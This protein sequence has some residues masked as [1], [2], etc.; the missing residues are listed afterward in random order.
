M[1][2]E[3]QIRRNNLLKELRKLEEKMDLP[4]TKLSLDEINDKL[5]LY[6]GGIDVKGIGKKCDK[7]AKLAKQMFWRK[8][9]E[10]QYSGTKLSEFTGDKSRFTAIAG[11]NYHILKCKNNWDVR[12]EYIKFKEFLKAN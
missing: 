9:V 7:E 2:K 5:K 11:R 3:L 4:V 1:L 12:Q 6:T 8:G 10:L